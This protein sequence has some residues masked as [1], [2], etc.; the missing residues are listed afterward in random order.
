LQAS[1]RQEGKPT[2]KNKNPA[3]KNRGHPLP[4]TA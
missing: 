1:R 4:R 3:L 2:R